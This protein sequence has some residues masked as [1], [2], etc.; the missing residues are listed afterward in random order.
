MVGSGLRRLTAAFGVLWFTAAATTAAQQGSVN[1]TFYVDSASGSDANPGTEALPWKTVAKVNSTALKPG[2][3]V[4]FK[5]NGVWREQLISPSS[6]TPDSPITFGAYGEGALPVFLGSIRISFWTPD[7]A[8]VYRTTGITWVPNMVFQDGTY[9][10]KATGRASMSPGSFYVDTGTNVLYIWLATQDDPSAHAIEVSANSAAPYGMIQDGYFGHSYLVFDSLE[11]KYANWAAFRVYG[12]QYITIRNCTV[13]Y[14]YDNAIV[15]IGTSQSAPGDPDGFVVTDN[16]ISHSGMYRATAGASGA[17]AIALDGSNPF[18]IRGNHIDTSYGEGIVAVNGAANGDISN[19]VITNQQISGAIYL[20]VSGG[21][22]LQNVQVTGNAIYNG[23]AP[24]AIIALL[25]AV[26]GAG[27]IA[28][29]DV[30]YNLVDNW[31]SGYGI[32]IG[33]GD[34]TITQIRV[35]NN[36]VSGVAYGFLEQGNSTMVNNTIENN[37]FAAT[38]CGV[39]VGTGSSGANTLNYNLYLPNAGVIFY[40]LGEYYDFS[41]FQS[42]SGQEVNGL[43]AAPLFTDVSAEDFTLGSGSPAIGAGVYVPG[44]STTNPPNLGAN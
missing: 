14:A 17:E 34:G 4:G 2:Q 13:E 18:S 3:S 39:V 15:A 11:V 16:T 12:G 21:R 36:T 23:T 7:S 42:A 22:I 28:N 37:I 40:W 30:T 10:P 41:D 43:S 31:P 38:G 27:T 33:N 1:F 35:L 19:N 26:E 44:V 8:A 25:L 20:A 29:V 32:G 24:S 5:R 9:I 6:G